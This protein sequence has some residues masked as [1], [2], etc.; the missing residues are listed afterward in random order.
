[1]GNDTAVARWETP[2]HVVWSSSVKLNRG[3]ACVICG[4]TIKLTA[5]H[6]ASWDI[7]PDLRFD[8]S[9]GACVCWPCHERFH[10]EFG[11]GRNTREQWDIYVN[12][13]KHLNGTKTPKKLS[14]EE[15]QIRELGH[16]FGKDKE[17]R[18]R[19]I[20]NFLHIP[21]S[22]LNYCAKNNM[23]ECNV[24]TGGWT[25]TKLMARKILGGNWE[26]YTPPHEAMKE[27]VLQAY[28][29]I[30]G[31]DMIVPESNYQEWVSSRPQLS[32]WLCPME[33]GTI[34]TKL[35]N[36][37][38]WL[39]HMCGACACDTKIAEILKQDEVY[40]RAKAG[41]AARKAKEAQKTQDAEDY[42]WGLGII[43]KQHAR[44]V[45]CHTGDFVELRHIKDPA[46]YP[47]L[48]RDESNFKCLCT[49]CYDVFLKESGNASP[50]REQFEVFYNTHK[51]AYVP[52]SKQRKSVPAV[53]V[54]RERGP[55]RELSKVTF[56]NGTPQISD[57]DIA[58]IEA[59]DMRGL[60]GIPAMAKLSHNSEY[61]LRVAVGIKSEPHHYLVNDN[62]Y[63]SYDEA[64]DV[65]K[66]GHIS[67]VP[68]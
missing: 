65:M 42:W 6:I 54:E 27:I 41:R 22:V 62:C 46:I 19:Y 8:V 34:Y 61:A 40:Q 43:R 63:F 30:T 29:K 50:T 60:I 68:A 3:C 13:N 44:C 59:A 67:V 49:K 7:H 52:H 17:V 55:C 28:D 21:A 45:I 18:V 9:N 5:H 47:K 53:V 58:R 1:M 37:T 11:Y 2:E 56:T 31:E 36:F 39:K 20:A 35:V 26:S 38:P 66:L 4:R 25:M 16:V 14:P 51:V 23:F 48:R 64:L 32:S 24:A 12:G 10:S 57:A 15:V 33:E